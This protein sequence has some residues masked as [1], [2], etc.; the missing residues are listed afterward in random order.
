MRLPMDNY[1]YANPFLE[2]R[3]LE[4][5]A[6]RDEDDREAVAYPVVDLS[7]D[8]ERRVELSETRSAISAFIRDLSSRDRELVQRI[9]WQGQTQADVARSFR[10]SGA[11]I[12]K[13]MARIAARGRI[14][15]KS[16]RDCQLLHE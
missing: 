1:A 2:P 14:A 4:S 9:F 12:S 11:A 10:V 6:V 8:V 5:L 13:Q 7:A 15:L 3:S 16:F